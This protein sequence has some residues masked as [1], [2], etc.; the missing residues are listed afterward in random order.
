MRG[1]KVKALKRYGKDHKSW[2]SWSRGMATIACMKSGLF[3]LAYDGQSILTY[4]G[5]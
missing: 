5:T 1:G 3:H 2:W 4:L